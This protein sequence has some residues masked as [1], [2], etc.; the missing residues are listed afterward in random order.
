MLAAHPLKCTT[1]P[2][3]CERLAH[4]KT[5]MFSDVILLILIHVTIFFNF[6]EGTCNFVNF[7]KVTSTSDLDECMLKIADMLRKDIGNFFHVSFKTSYQSKPDNSRSKYSTTLSTNDKSW[8]NENKR[9]FYRDYIIALRTFNV[10]KNGQN[11]LNLIC[12]K[13][14]YKK[15]EAKL[16]RCTMYKQIEGNRVNIL[17]NNNPRQILGRLKKKSKSVRMF[18]KKICFKNRPCRVLILIVSKQLMCVFF[19]Y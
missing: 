11:H 6:I 19:F 13:R 4:I 3:P 18:L 7:E 9:F 12:K 16:R 10:C 8:F 1:L 17:K 5:E 2:D 15:L 14:T